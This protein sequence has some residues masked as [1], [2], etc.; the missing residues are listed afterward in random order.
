MKLHT[1][2]SHLALMTGVAAVAVA[3]G[4]MSAAQEPDRLRGIVEPLVA[5]ERFSIGASL[6]HLQDDFWKGIAYGIADEA[7]RSNVELVQI[8]VAGAY[9]NV[10][11]QFGQLDT[12]QSL[13]ADVIV[14]GPAA[15]DGYNLPL[16]RLTDAGVTVI[17][18]GI[19]VNSANVAFGVGQDDRAIG[20][21]QAEAL[22]ADV[23]GSAATV[24]TIPGPAGAEWAAQ[25]LVAFA[26]TVAEQ[27][28]S[29]TIVEG[30]AGS[31]LALEQG[32]A[33]AA[34]LMLKH[35]EALYIETPA[36][37]LGMGALQA[38]RQQQRDD[39]RVI[40]SGVVREVIPMVEDGSIM[41]I[42]S[43]PGIVM[44]R[45]IVQYAIRAREGLPMPGLGTETGTAYP[46]LMI[47][48]T[49]ITAETVEGYPFDLYELPPSDWTIGN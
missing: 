25:R 4:S 23:D 43:E 11:E 20:V 8:S 12:L 19:P 45:L 39:V 40:T 14:V 26:A 3:V 24:L 7:E 49:M 32:L 22:C 41:A 28:P 36:V 6:V 5:T 35:P 27:C 33:Q 30:A 1:R 18:A 48:A 44:G 15:Y 47:P 2:K 17:A 37:S 10:R 13:G 16:G 21:A 9:G 34:D 31:S 29:V 38:I 46:A 42:G